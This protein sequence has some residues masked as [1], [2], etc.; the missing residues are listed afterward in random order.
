MLWPM[1]MTAS[2]ESTGIPCP[3]PAVHTLSLHRD[4]SPGLLLEIR[5][6]FSFTPPKSVVV[7]VKRA[8]LMSLSA[9]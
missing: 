5:T 7:N 9:I 8:L 3:P 1:M 4:A 6:T 2:R